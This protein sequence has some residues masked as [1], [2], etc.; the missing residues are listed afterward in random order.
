[1]SELER[2]SAFP[3][4]M[5]FCKELGLST[6]PPCFADRQEH[7]KKMMSSHKLAFHLWYKQRITCLDSVLLCFAHCALPPPHRGSAPMMADYFGSTPPWVP[8]FLCLP[9]GTGKQQSSAWRSHPKLLSHSFTAQWSQTRCGRTENHLNCQ[10][11]DLHNL[12][13][14]LEEWLQRE[15][16]LFSQ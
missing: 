16:M 9:R 13:L 6:K 1:M 4:L 3:Q 2:I 7:K 8:G 14:P 5:F 10:Q 11:R 15:N 12:L